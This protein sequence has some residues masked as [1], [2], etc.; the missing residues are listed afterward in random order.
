MSTNEAIFYSKMNEFGDYKYNNR[1]DTLFVLQ[2][3]FIIIL[4]FIGL[5]YLSLY[6][7]F[8]KASMYIITMLL[9]VVLTLVIINKAVVM[10]KLR[11]KLIWDTYNFGNGQEKPTT[12][13]EEAGV[14]GGVS[15]T[16]PNS[17]CETRVVCTQGLQI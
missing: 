10:P 5:Y 7:F 13:Y 3:S 12:K 6:G 11:S 9:T 4:V 15:G 1:L 2:L 17:T 16:S 8:S 14:D